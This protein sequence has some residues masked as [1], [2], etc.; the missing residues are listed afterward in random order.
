M[1][2]QRAGYLKQ[3][4][5]PVNPWTKPSLPVGPVS[6]EEALKAAGILWKSTTI[7]EVNDR[8]VRKPALEVVA[9]SWVN[10]LR[11]TSRSQ[12]D[13]VSLPEDD[14]ADSS[15]SD[16][17]AEE[18][19]LS[20]ASFAGMSKDQLIGSMLSI[21]SELLMSFVPRLT[22]VVQRSNLH[23]TLG[24]HVTAPLERQ[25]RAGVLGRTT[26]Q[27]I[28]ADIE[29]MILPSWAG[30]PSSSVGRKGRGKLKA[31]EWRT[32]CNVNL[33]HTLPRLWHGESTNVKP[34]YK[35]LLD[36]FMDLVTA[37][38]LASSRILTPQIISRH[39]RSIRQYLKGLRRLFPHV[40]LSPNQHLSVHLTTMLLDFG[41]T[42]A[43]RC[44]PF[45]RYNYILQQINTSMKFGMK[46]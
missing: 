23:S 17:G 24:D 31:D 37:T 33:V 30:K 4:G 9:T 1:Q 32:F 29:A 44:F 13:Q 12:Q 25:K 41:P 8:G 34:R 27:E 45:E 22:H 6:H 7:A 43:W 2:R 36:N 3:D 19:F 20:E 11:E 35:D 15:G 21:V 18:S 10:Y 40:D 5:T 42:H 28:W 39:S 46:I 14:N 38:K 16:L 26:L